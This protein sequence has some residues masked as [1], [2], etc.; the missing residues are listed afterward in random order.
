MIRFADVEEAQKM[1]P[2]VGFHTPSQMETVVPPLLEN[3]WLTDG[4]TMMVSQL[5]LRSRDDALM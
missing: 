1:F 4:S 2:D 5:M 3:F